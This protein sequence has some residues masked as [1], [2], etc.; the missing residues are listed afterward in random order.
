MK[1][2]ILRI[3]K[4]PLFMS[5][6]SLTACDGAGT[7]P[8]ELS[9]TPA[10]VPISV[11]S[12]PI[13]VSSPTTTS[14]IPEVTS[15]AS[16]SSEASSSAIAVMEAN[17]GRDQVITENVKTTLNGQILLNNK[18]LERSIPSN[19]QWKQ[20]A[21][22]EPLAQRVNGN[23]LD[24]ITPA[25][26]TPTTINY[27]LTANHSE[28][29]DTD[30]V[31]IDILPCGSF[32]GS[33]FDSCL[34]YPF[35]PWLSYETTQ[36]I[37][38]FGD[39]GHV[40]WQQASRNNNQIMRVSWNANDPKNTSDDKGWFG[41]DIAAKNS[42]FSEY[43]DGAI[44]FGIR[45]IENTDTSV[46]FYFRLECGAGC[47]S[48]DF[49]IRPS[50]INNQWNKII[51]PLAQ[52]SASG[53]DL[54]QL[55]RG[56]FWPKWESQAHKITAEIDNIKLV[57]NYTIPK[58]DECRGTGNVTYTLNRKD[59]PTNAEAKI[60]D[61]INL[62]MRE[63][64]EI[65]NC[66][67][68]LERALNVF[69]NPKVPTANASTGGF[70]ITFGKSR[71][72]RTA[73]HE[74]GHIFGAGTGNYKTWVVDGRVTSPRVNALV[75]KILNDPKAK[76]NGGDVHIWPFGMNY[77]RED[78]AQERVHHSLVIEAL[79]HDQLT[80]NPNPVKSTGQLIRQKSQILAEPIACDH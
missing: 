30:T 40:Q 70:N 24:F 15:L 39:A 32:S 27:Q 37:D 1:L 67:T 50:Q 52:L 57:K 4:L 17:A 46:P 60:Y 26:A 2:H 10:S 74:L 35:G 42:D 75:K 79:Y 38:Y 54:S 18:P 13:S 56:L 25:Q 64:V 73:L 22:P 51:I 71:S 45:F 53:L 80:A 41:F 12:T 78:G 65:Y 23:Q 48:D 36:G 44:E 33:V 66:H 19:Y 20:I 7:E 6:L 14:S 29:T 3:Y 77:D 43:A 31:G 16:S 21:G 11:S 49:A 69:Y 72:T 28:Q 58:P 9:T 55:S 76:L 59:N 62:Y 5:I 63:A 68:H 8:Q 34:Q 47:R 61:D